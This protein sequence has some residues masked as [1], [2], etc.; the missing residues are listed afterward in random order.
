MYNKRIRINELGYDFILSQLPY[1][2]FSKD[3]P[4]ITITLDKSKVNGNISVRNRLNGDKIFVVGVGNKKLKNVF[5]ENKI[6]E[7]QRKNFPVL[8]DEKNVIS[9]VGLRVSD[10]YKPTNNSNEKIYIYVWRTDAL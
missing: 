10:L 2:N 4:F 9:L 5:S 7:N 1:L 8:A 6:L 3:N